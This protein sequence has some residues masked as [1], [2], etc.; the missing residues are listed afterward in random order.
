[1]MMY[2]ATYS[3]TMK[4]FFHDFYNPVDKSFY[5]I[6]FIGVNRFF[7]NIGDWGNTGVVNEYSL[8][9][10]LNIIE[11][12]ISNRIPNLEKIVMEKILDSI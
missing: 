1:M 12:D 7:Y 4:I 3:S 2:L 6:S 8:P 11:C 9:N 10:I 5:S